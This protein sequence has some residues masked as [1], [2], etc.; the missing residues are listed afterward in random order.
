MVPS[1]MI[2][3]LDRNDLK[4]DLELDNSMEGSLSSENGKIHVVSKPIQ[5]GLWVEEDFH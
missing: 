3:L 2:G 1:D 4:A 5:I